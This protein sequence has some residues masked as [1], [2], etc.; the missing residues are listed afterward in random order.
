MRH[1]L[2]PVPLACKITGSP[3]AF[4]FQTSTQPDS[5]VLNAANGKSDQNLSDFKT[6]IGTIAHTTLGTVQL[7]SHIRT[8]IMDTI[9]YM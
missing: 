3:L 9:T 6:G 8:A 4:G 2:L 7:I 5:V 1:L